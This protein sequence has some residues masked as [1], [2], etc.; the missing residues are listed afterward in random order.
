MH[1]KAYTLPQK[2]QLDSRLRLFKLGLTV[3]RA[4]NSL[5]SALFP[6][7]VFRNNLGFLLLLDLEWPSEVTP[8]SPSS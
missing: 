8:H 7:L 4:W 6:N 5:H 1:L 3:A 2:N